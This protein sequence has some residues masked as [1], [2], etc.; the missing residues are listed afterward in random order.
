MQKLNWKRDCC[1][2]VSFVEMTASAQQHDAH[3]A[4]RAKEQ[5]AGVRARRR[6]RKVRNACKRHALHRVA[7]VRGERLAEA[8][9]EHHRYARRADRIL[10]RQPKQQSVV[11]RVAE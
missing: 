7:E 6:R 9:A 2:R 10:C 8:R 5:L 3:A 4:E 11:V 1:G